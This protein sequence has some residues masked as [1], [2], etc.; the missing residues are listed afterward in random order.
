M[1]E[2]YQNFLKTNFVIF[3]IETSGLDPIRDEILEIAAIKLIGDKE[4]GRF[5]ALIQPTRPVS[6]EVEKI[7][8]LNELF[9][10]AN[11]RRNDEVMTDFFGFLGDAIVSGHNIRGFDWLFILEHLRRKKQP[12]LQNKIIDTLELSRQLLSLPTYNLASVA[13]HFGLEHK[14]AHRAMPDVEVNT[15]VFLRLMEKLFNSPGV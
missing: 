5:E 10:L 2:K 1:T 8:G 4:A 9:L 14:N 13:G 11:G 12:F 7:H 6:P 15:K 3:D